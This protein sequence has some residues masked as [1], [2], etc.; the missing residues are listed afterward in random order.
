MSSGTEE[1]ATLVQRV[2]ELQVALEAASRDKGNL[3]RE[4]GRARAEI[5]CLRSEQRAAEAASELAQLERTARIRLMLRDTH[6]R[7]P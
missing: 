2:R 3:R 1:N 4:L 6:S 7:N 5:R